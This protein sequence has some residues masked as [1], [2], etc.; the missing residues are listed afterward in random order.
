MAGVPL[1]PWQQRPPM[2][3]AW[4]SR[5]GWWLQGRRLQVTDHLLEAGKR[6][7]GTGHSGE[8]NRGF[9]WVYDKKGQTEKTVFDINQQTLWLH[10]I[11]IF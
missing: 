9:S 3:A 7:S 8:T 5:I 6:P 2:W 11:A 1:V 10:P 4:T